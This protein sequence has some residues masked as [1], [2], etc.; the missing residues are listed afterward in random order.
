MEMWER[1]EQRKKAV[2]HPSLH[3]RSALKFSIIY[4]AF[5]FMS[6]W[7]KKRAQAAYIHI[8]HSF[9]DSSSACIVLNRNWP[10]FPRGREVKSNLAKG[11]T[12]SGNC[13]FERFFFVKH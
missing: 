2:S 12:M 13:E 10:T 3:V 1:K 4:E 8:C 5:L 6:G 7:E 11:K 9:S